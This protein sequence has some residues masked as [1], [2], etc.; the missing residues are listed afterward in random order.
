[1]N[2]ASSDSEDLLVSIVTIVYNGENHLEQTIQSVLSQ[3]YSNIEYFIIDGGSTDGTVGIIRKYESKLAGWISERDRGISDAFNK[4]L[5]LASGELIGLINA[6]DWYEQ[7]CVEKIV[8]GIGEHDIAYGDVQYWKS[9]R[10]SIIREGNHHLL[11]NEMTVN[12]P[13]VFIRRKCYLELGNF[14]TEFRC[15][16][17]YD[18]IL[19]FFL[20]GKRFVRIPYVLANM[21]L[22][23]ISDKQW[24]IGCEETLTIKNKYFPERKIKNKI[25]YFKHLLAIGIP[26]KLDQLHLGFISRVYRKYFSELNKVPKK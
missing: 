6:D 1:M 15:A 2:I 11:I 5:A 24:K 4:G 25:Y 18:V 26:K 22:E 8:T 19:R 3:T 23:G 21:R 7:N 12:H 9:G 17:D 20:N 10:K 14:N 13:T 16:M